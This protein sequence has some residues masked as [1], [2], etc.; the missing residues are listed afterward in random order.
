MGRFTNGHQ[1]FRLKNLIWGFIILGTLAT[2]VTLGAI[3]LTLRE[4]RI[5]GKP[6]NNPPPSVRVESPPERMEPAALTALEAFFEAP[7][8]KSKIDLARDS[9]RVRP[10]MEDYHNRRGHPFPTLG[11]VSRGQVA[12][13]NETPMV[14]FEVEPFSGPRYPVAV[15]WDGHRFSVDW[16]SLTAYGTVDWSEF[17]E[18]QP[19]EP[20]TLRVFI[21]PANE[22]EQIPGTAKDVTFFRI[23]HRDDPQPLIVSANAKIAGI[24][25]SLIK[26]KQRTPVTLEASWKPTGPGGAMVPEIVRIVSFRWSP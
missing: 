19:T 10:M 17:L 25:G 12:R 22:S 18:A 26:G 20:Q 9:A 23:E 5:H 4:R 16:E 2:L 24:L 14:L 11:R 21:C 8:L 13:F 1:V 3:V 15:V 6:Q 7:D